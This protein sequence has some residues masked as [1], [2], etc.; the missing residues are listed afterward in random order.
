[1]MTA[2]VLQRRARMTIIPLNLPLLIA[3]SRAPGHRVKYR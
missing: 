2:E 3:E 1:M